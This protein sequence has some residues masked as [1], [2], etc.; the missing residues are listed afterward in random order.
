MS[1]VDKRFVKMKLVAAASVEEIPDEYGV[2]ALVGDDLFVRGDSGIIPYTA[3]TA[4]ER[5][6]LES[7][8]LDVTGLE[9]LA[10]LSQNVSAADY[11]DGFTIYADGVE[12]TISSAVRETNHAHLTFTVAAPIDVGA[13]VSIVYAASL[14]SVVGETGGLVLRSV[15]FAVT[16]ESLYF[17][18]SAGY[19][20][21][22]DGT[23]STAFGGANFMP[24]EA[25]TYHKASY[26]FA[27]T[28]DTF[29][30][31]LP[32]DPFDTDAII[33]AAGSKIAMEAVFLAVPSQFSLAGLSVIPSNA[34][35]ATAYPQFIGLENLDGNSP[36]VSSFS[37]A[38]VAI[39]N[40]SA[41]HGAKGFRVGIIVDADTGVITYV[42]S[43]G[44]EIVNSTPLTV[45]DA[46]TFMLGATENNTSTDG[47]VISI[48]L[49]PN[50]IDMKLT[51]PAGTVDWD[52]TVIGS[53]VAPDLDSA[54]VLEADPSTL[55]LTFTDDVITNAADFAVGI[56]VTVNGDAVAVTDP[57]TSVG[58]VVNLALA[59]AVASGDVVVVSYDST[60]GG[61]Q[62][63]TGAK[64]GS[65]TNEAVVNGSVET[66]PAFV[67]A[68]IGVV[69]ESTLVITLDVA[70][71]SQTNDYES[72]FSVS[73]NATP[74]T[75]TA[76]GNVGGTT[77]S[78]L[79]D[80]PVVDSDVVLVSYDH[81]AGDIVDSTSGVPLSDFTGEAV[82]N[83]APAAPAFAS[84]EIGTVDAETLVITF[85]S[86][87]TSPLNNYL[88]GIS[89]NVNAAP[90]TF[91]DPVNAGGTTVSLT[92]DTPVI[93]TDVVT[94]SYNAGAGD[95]QAASTVPVASFTDEAVTNNV[96]P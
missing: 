46:I 27:Y 48:A 65:F 54:V 12:Q 15:T 22:D 60:P 88:A 63:A 38:P 62:S 2:V 89:V 39:S 61:I 1:T 55:V 50:A 49:V 26:T 68:E 78:L 25:P 81:T 75:F 34:G 90:A 74:V 28:A 4:V 21:D 43:D 19:A 79:L 36:V 83:T 85:S 73:V 35:T 42:T 6:V 33:P 94:V 69:D 56:S 7:A 14:G 91:T 80:S 10:V 82:V 76:P 70:V 30:M 37:G 9:I 92:L 3:G 53:G 32:D 23:A 52:G 31:C 11:G 17:Q 67:S 57:D 87:I 41:V 95:L 96:A 18:N 16:N 5:P 93:N 44:V 20:L 45:G 29:A 77:I 40:G 24:A 84:A 51:Y 47:D 13:R 58:D 66:H 59:F 71:E 86:A 72:G 64:V 8:T